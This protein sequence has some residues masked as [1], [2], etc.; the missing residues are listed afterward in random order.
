M[1]ID[2]LKH[3]VTA[4]ITEEKKNIQEAIQAE[5]NAWI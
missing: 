3:M 2:K 4:T 1:K 5:R